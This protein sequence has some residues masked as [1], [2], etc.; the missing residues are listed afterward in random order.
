MRN[1]NWREIDG[2]HKV[3]VSM[4]ISYLLFMILALGTGYMIY[5]ETIK[6]MKKD[7]TDNHMLVL[8]QNKAVLERR[9]EELTS[10]ARQTTANTKVI[11]FM[12]ETDPYKGTNTY[13]VIDTNKSL[14]N[15]KLFN[16][17]IH[18][19]YILYKNS[20]F[21]MTP[22]SNYTIDEFFNR[23]SVYE[24]KGIEDMRQSWLE[25][26]HAGTYIPQA[27][28]QAG[29]ASYSMLTYLQ[30]IGLP[31]NPQG[32]IAIQIDQSEI[33]KIFQGLNLSDG[34]WAYIFDAKGN[35]ISSLTG[36]P[37]SVPIDP[38]TLTGLRG[39]SEKKLNSQNF[40]VTYT[41]SN[42]NGWTYLVGQPS[43]L[44]LAKVRYIQKTVFLTTLLFLAIG[45]T[46]AYLLAYRNT[47]PI[48]N[49]VNSIR[50]LAGTGL[51]HRDVYGYIRE[52]V[53]GLASS[54][55]SLQSA[56]EQQVPLLRAIYF[57]RLMLGQFLSA[58]D[59]DA[60]LKHVGLD[61]QGEG[62]LYTVALF[63]IGGFDQGDY[64]YS[65]DLLDDLDRVRLA[66]LEVLRELAGSE[67][68]AYDIAEDQIA[69][70]LFCSPDNQSQQAI[71]LL[72]ENAMNVIYDQLKL[73]A[74]CGIGGLS[75]SLTSIS[76]SFMQA[77]EALFVLTRQQREGFQW[78]D[79][80]P[81]EMGG[82]YYPQDVEG[83]L[84]N[85]AIS[86][87]RE[88]VERT[89]DSIYQENFN[90]RQLSQAVIRLLLSELWGS[91]AKLLPQVGLEV[92]SVYSRIQ[93]LEGLERIHNSPRIHFEAIR[94][95]YGSICNRV[96]EQRSNR[97]IQLLDH[98]LALLQDSYMDKE[99]CLDVAA[100]RLRISK[101]YLSQFFKEQ[102]GI[103][104]SDY[105]ENLRMNQAK[106]LLK[107]TSLSVQEIADR[108]GYSSSNTFGRAFKRLH[109]V[110]ATVYQSSGDLELSRLS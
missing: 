29:T 31:G 87:D 77:K 73:V 66:A 65:D 106:H 48:R 21:V 81:I 103:N 55:Q 28:V 25:K 86:G 95:M 96:H 14:Y 35:V 46:V 56:V 99:M 15:Y 26:Y 100:D 84:M 97:N 20:D 4:L 2:R 85:V 10:I 27:K 75:N 68:F 69:V 52:A 89:L 40:T 62:R 94:G 7:A 80:L 72:I 3:L 104:F 30:S 51:K 61:L 90:N 64:G 42:S 57:R 13:S 102:T 24:G 16:N 63:R 91:L 110:S 70:L 22:G 98:T 23:I 9:L 11:Q 1:W 44:V 12:M 38:A 58:R 53:S 19:Y 79:R 33:H 49:L 54:N 109:G 83:R 41:K 6:V 45:I 82:Y 67:G 59:A 5:K 107:H 105:L 47:R 8:E 60:L 34:G 32:V 50:E 71:E 78:Y 93:Q 92:D 39:V 18:N 17:F 108:V 43:D 76:R 37:D 101:V 36:P 88:E 74:A